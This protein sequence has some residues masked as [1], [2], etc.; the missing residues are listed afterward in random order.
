MLGCYQ[1]T[2][3]P[4]NQS[5]ELSKGGPPFNQKIFPSMELISI[6]IS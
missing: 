1:R 4:L 3:H 6:F 2:C 5:L